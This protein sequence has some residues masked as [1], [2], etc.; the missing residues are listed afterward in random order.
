MIKRVSS[1]NELLSAVGDLSED[2]ANVGALKIYALWLCYGIKYD[3]CRF[4]AADGAVICGLD[5][6]FVVSDYGK[7]DFEELAG[8]FMSVGYSEIFCSERV[9]DGLSEYMRCDRY[10]VDLMRFNGGVPPGAECVTEKDTPLEDFY[11]ILKTAFDIGFEP[12]YLDMSHRI[13]HGVTRTRR[14]GGSVL[15]IQ[16]D[17][18]GSALIS[19]V[20]TVPSERGKGGASRLISSVCAELSDSEVY[21]ICEDA[22]CGFYKKS[23]FSK[24]C[25]KCILKPAATGI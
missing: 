7:C 4:Y 15:V 14:L 11:S 25:K 17:L 24:L 18:F 21:V 9:G 19:Q 6:S 20:A 10:N 2:K 22:L 13:R 12:W 8:F 23:R 16:H 5:G 3:F 1:D